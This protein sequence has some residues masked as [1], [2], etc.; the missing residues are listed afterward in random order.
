MRRYDEWMQ[1]AE[2]RYGEQ[3]IYAFEALCL[4]EESIQQLTD[5]EVDLKIMHALQDMG[6]C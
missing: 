1:K 2:D 3:G 4:T 5:S 6:G